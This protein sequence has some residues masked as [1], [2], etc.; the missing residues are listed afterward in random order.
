MGDVSVIA[1]RLRDG[2]VQYGWSGNGGYYKMLGNR[3][4]RWYNNKDEDNIEYLFGLGELRLLGK[5]GSERGGA[6]WLET[7]DLTHTPHNLGMSER[8]IFSKIAFVDYGYFDDWVVIRCDEAFEQVTGVIM[9][10]KMD[11]RIETNE[12]EL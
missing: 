11:I 7:H 1:R 3:L 6:L 9:K 8:E 10:K 12:W 4:L 2:H 5:P